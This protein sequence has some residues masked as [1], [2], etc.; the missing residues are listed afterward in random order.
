LFRNE[1]NLFPLSEA[2]AHRTLFIVAAGDDDAD[3]GSVFKSAIEQRIPGARVIKVDR[4]T[5][6]SEYDNLEKEAKRAENVVIGA[7]VKRAALKGTV[8]LPQAEADFIRELIDDKR[9]VAV[10]AFGSPYQ[11]QQLPKVRSYMAAWA[12]E[13]A[14]QTAGAR[15]VF[16]EIAIRGHSPVSLPG[17]FKLGD[18]MQVARQKEREKNAKE[19][20]EIF[21]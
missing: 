17:F 3:Q 19:A 20:T 18:G 16:G 7:F 12:V 1:E 8:E 6:E 13:D 10:V 14:A 11:I 15:A 9:E 2:A 5:T 21:N 4:R